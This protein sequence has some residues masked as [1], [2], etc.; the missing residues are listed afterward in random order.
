MSRQQKQKLLS[1]LDS[2]VWRVYSRPVVF[3]Y[4]RD[5]KDMISAL[6]KKQSGDSSK[7]NNWVFDYIDRYP[8]IRRWHE[9]SMDLS[10]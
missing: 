1:R 4:Q 6:E 2:I 8:L 7:M 9:L 3:T 10:I 5:I